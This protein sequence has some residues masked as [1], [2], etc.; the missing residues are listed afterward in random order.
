M[1]KTIGKSTDASVN[2][3]NAK[4]SG[5]SPTFS[6]LHFQRLS[7]FY[8]SI[9]STANSP[10]WETRSKLREYTSVVLMFV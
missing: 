8:S 1:A 6:F 7:L 10:A 2:A 4:R 3:T 5:D 9:L